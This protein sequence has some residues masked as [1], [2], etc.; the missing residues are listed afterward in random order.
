MTQRLDPGRPIRITY[1]VANIGDTAA[2]MR[3]I[4]TTLWFRTASGQ[5]FTPELKDAEL[6][7]LIGGER[8][9]Y[10][11]ATTVLQYNEA[12]GIHE[13][14]GALE[15]RGFIVYANDNTV[16]RQTGF[17]RA[18]SAQTGRFRPKDGPDADYEY[19]D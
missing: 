19:Q 15:F 11:T 14:K 3:H 1:I 6:R 5:E 18:Y 17:W 7:T 10:V 16:D 12:W 2:H 13:G 8:C 4:E 9:L